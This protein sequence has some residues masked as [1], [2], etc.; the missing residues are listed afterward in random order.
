MEKSVAQKLRLGIFVILEP[1]FLL[2]LFILLE[3][4]SNFLVKQKP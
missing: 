4:D 1:S 2:W 3:T